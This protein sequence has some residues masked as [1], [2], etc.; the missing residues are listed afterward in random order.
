[1]GQVKW[2]QRYENAEINTVTVSKFFVTV[3]QREIGLNQARDLNC[4]LTR[5]SR[6]EKSDQVPDC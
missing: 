3:V 6:R 4:F 2:K 1:M 5:F